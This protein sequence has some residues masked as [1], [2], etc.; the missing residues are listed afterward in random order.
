MKIDHELAI[1]LRE[2]AR[3]GASEAL[4]Q[5]GLSESHISKSKAYKLYGRTKVDKWIS[6]GLVQFYQDQPNS[7]CLISVSGLNAIIASE[8]LVQFINITPGE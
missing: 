2:A 4:I 1:L 5:A 6:S 3:L 8:S 7:K